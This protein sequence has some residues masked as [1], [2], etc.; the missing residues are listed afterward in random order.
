[1]SRRHRRWRRSCCRRFLPNS[2]RSRRAS[3]QPPPPQSIR[4]NRRAAPPSPLELNFAAPALCAGARLLIPFGESHESFITPWRWHV[5]HRDHFR[6]RRFNGVR[7]RRKGSRCRA[8]SRI[9][10]R[11]GYKRRGFARSRCQHDDTEQQ[12]HRVRA[13]DKRRSNRE[14]DSRHI[15]ALDTRQPA[16]SDRPAILD[17]RLRHIHQY[18]YIADDRRHSRQRCVFPHG[19]LESD[20]H[21]FH[22][23]TRGHSRRRRVQPVGQHGDGR[24]RQYHHQ[25]TDIRRASGFELWQLQYPKSPGRG[26]N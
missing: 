8:H 3:R 10:H 13:A 24:Y 16:S 15:H 25:A 12:R 4:R 20:S 26:G 2:R 11:D 21:Q 18:Q 9:C 1:M 14:Q 22:Q 7:G 23:D 6:H 5:R 17:P 19:R